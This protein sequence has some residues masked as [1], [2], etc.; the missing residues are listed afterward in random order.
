MFWHSAYSQG[1]STWKLSIENTHLT[2]VMGVIEFWLC[3]EIVV[4]LIKYRVGWCHILHTVE[5]A[6]RV[7]WSHSFRWISANELVIQITKQAT[8]YHNTFRYNCKDFRAF[9]FKLIQSIF[10]IQFAYCIFVI[11]WKWMNESIRNFVN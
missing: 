11:K 9:H 5:C 10:Q 8:V 6:Q 2:S 1:V 3:I 4:R 7:N